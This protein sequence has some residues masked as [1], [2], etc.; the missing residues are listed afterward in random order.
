LT[1]QIS[2]L[3]SDTDV[4]KEKLERLQAKAPFFLLLGRRD[5]RLPFLRIAEL[6]LC[7]I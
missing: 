1:L 6:F 7:S 5:F 2:S 3:L 4:L